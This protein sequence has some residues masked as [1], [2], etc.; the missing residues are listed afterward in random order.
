VVIFG[1]LAVSRV[2]ITVE[3]VGLGAFAVLGAV[4]ASCL[5]VAMGSGTADFSDDA[6][7]AL[8][9]GTLYLFLVVAA[10]FN[11]ALLETGAVRLRILAL[12]AAGLGLHW[13]AG[14]DGGARVFDPHGPQRRV[15]S[16]DGATLAIMLFLGARA[17]QMS[18][19]VETAWAGAIWPALLGGGAAIYLFRRRAIDPSGWALLPAL[20]AGAA[21]GVLASLVHLHPHLI[22]ALWPVL[23]RALADE[24]IVRGMIQRGLVKRG[25]ILAAALAAFVA[26]M[27]G[28]RPL[29]LD[30]V[31]VAS[32]PGLA[33]ALTRRWPAALAAR[34]ALEL[35]L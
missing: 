29:G 32:I 23:L 12:Y 9:P 21:T 28:A 25:R 16:A 31:L 20:A 18:G 34:L 14:I 22:A 3:A 19:L 15:S 5:A 33:M 7:R 17:Q 6:R 26:L 13:A 30:A 24:L 2:P 27:A 4:A 11:V 1:L 35:L 8:G 10:L